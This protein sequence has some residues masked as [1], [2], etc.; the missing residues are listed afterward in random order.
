VFSQP[1]SVKISQGYVAVRL[2]GGDDLDDEAR[3]FA[4]RYGV[5][6]FPTLFAMSAGGAVLDRA[7]P[8]TL[9][10]ILETMEKAT[11]AEKAFLETQA[12]LQKKRDPASLRV[13]A[14]LYRKRLEFSLAQQALE[15]IP[16][17]Q[18]TLEDDVLLLEILRAQDEVA[19]SKALLTRLVATHPDDARA[20]EWRI[21]LALADI[22]TAYASREQREAGERASLAALQALLPG[23]T[24]T[25]DEAAVRLALARLLSGTRD[26]EDALEHYEW[27][28]ENARESD[29]AAEAL[30]GK[31]GALFKGARGDAAALEAVKRLLEEIVERHPDHPA[32]SDAR[33]Y[34]VAVQKSIDKARADAEA[35][36]G[37]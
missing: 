8:R 30:M 24:R 17:A 31:A 11:L 7:L 4:L 35:D 32:A 9:D 29:S 34:I 28:L 18:R 21:A 1:D 14:D 37:K 27:I 2:L 16:A 36:A 25:A 10:G 3:A 5:R 23:L 13:L 33:R 19:G 26:R 20:I 22:P 6:S 12:A 15:K